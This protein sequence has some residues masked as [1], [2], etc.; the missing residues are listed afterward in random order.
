[1]EIVEKLEENPP[2][3]NE[4]G[5]AEGDEQEQ[6][7]HLETKYGREVY[8]LE[9]GMFR[10]YPLTRKML[11]ERAS[12]KNFE[13]AKSVKKTLSFLSYMM[14]REKAEIATSACDYLMDR[15]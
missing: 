4:G 5:E 11:K 7:D 1:M 9:E 8:E 14:K 13:V 2:D 10:L 3:F 15:V 12:Y 6:L